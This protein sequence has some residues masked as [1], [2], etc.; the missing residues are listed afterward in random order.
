MTVTNSYEKTLFNRF[1]I[2]LR[3]DSEPYK[4]IIAGCK[5]QRFTNEES[6]RI[7]FKNANGRALLSHNTNEKQIFI[8][9]KAA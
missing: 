4:L 9:Y 6:A 1:K 8:D 2:D 7:A 5:A 3:N